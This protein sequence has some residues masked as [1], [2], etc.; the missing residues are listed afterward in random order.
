MKTTPRHL[1]PSAFIPHP[2]L[3]ICIARTE[4]REIGEKL[5]VHWELP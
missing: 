5:T 2:L 3:E 1:H 4:V